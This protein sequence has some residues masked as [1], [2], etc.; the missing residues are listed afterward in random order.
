MELLSLVNY[1]QR[2]I[3]LNEKLNIITQEARY[4]IISNDFKNEVTMKIKK[5]FDDYNYFNYRDNLIP[6]VSF[7]LYKINI[8]VKQIEAP[9]HPSLTGGEGWNY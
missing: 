2:G 8:D 5:A 6:T 1:F 7:D 9:L 4:R 3:T